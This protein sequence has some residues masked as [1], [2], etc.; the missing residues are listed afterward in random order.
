MLHVV[1]P[2][3]TEYDGMGEP[4]GRLG[5][6]LRGA[7]LRNVFATR[8][9]EWVA[10]SV[11]TS[12]QLRDLVALASTETTADD[13][14][15]E[16]VLRAWV[17]TLPRSEVVERLVAA[18]IPVAPV[19]TARDVLADPHVRA[20]TMLRTVESGEHGPVSVPAAAPRLLSADAPDTPRLAEVGEHTAAVLREWGEA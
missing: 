11:S 10:T 4:P 14:D 12:R 18:R 9:G 7:L 13:A 19:N 1:A 2:I 16:D 5:S 6:R 15:P 20:R 8:D 17:A 3:F